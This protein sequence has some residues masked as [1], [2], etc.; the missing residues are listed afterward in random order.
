MSEKAILQGPFPMRIS[1]LQ[2]AV[3]MGRTELRLSVIMYKEVF[4]EAREYRQYGQEGSECGIKN[5]MCEHVNLF[6]TELNLGYLLLVNG[7]ELK[8]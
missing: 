6:V 5:L 1:F 3:G 2:G 4:T 8:L 7:K